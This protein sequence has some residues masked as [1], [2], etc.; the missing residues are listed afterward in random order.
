MRTESSFLA[1]ESSCS[2]REGAARFVPGSVSRPERTDGELGA[3]G[4]DLV[5]VDGELGFGFGDLGGEGGEKFVGFGDGGFRR[6]ADAALAT[7]FGFAGEA[8]LFSIWSWLTVWRAVASS[9]LMPLRCSCTWPMA[10]R[11]RVAA[12]ASSLT[13]CWRT[14]SCE[15]SSWTRA[16]TFF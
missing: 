10:T 11:G 16:S 3:E 7:K 13:S 14:M 6:V 5:G 1:R 4:G 2:R 9:R 12:S 8:D 15:P